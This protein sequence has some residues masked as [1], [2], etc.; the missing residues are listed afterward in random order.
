M[1]SSADVRDARA[2]HPRTQATSPEL[3]MCDSS[4]AGPSN[5]AMTAMTQ[6]TTCSKCG[7]HMEPGFMLERGH[8]PSDQQVRWVEGEPTPRLFFSG[9]K[10]GG[11]HPMPV[12]TF[13][14]DRCGYLESF[15]TPGA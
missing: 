10:L 8:G 6:P 14:C 4:A 7:G 5:E 2:V 15:A 1:F 3:P 11:R 13:R 12:T 9:V